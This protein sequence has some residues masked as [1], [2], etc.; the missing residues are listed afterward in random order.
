MLPCH[1]IYR[2]AQLSKGH[3]WQRSGSPGVES[4]GMSKLPEQRPRGLQHCKNH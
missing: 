2:S 4:Q 1:A 3:E